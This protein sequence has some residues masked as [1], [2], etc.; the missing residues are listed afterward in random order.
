MKSVNYHLQRM[1]ES[2]MLQYMYKQYLNYRK[3]KESVCSS[4]S[5]SA[6]ATISE[7]GIWEVDLGGT[8]TFFVLLTLGGLLSILLALAE[9]KLSKQMNQTSYVQ[10]QR[11]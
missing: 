11:T 6:T 10:Q 2:G 5:A 4:V 7:G 8:K 1:Y 9:K 3:T